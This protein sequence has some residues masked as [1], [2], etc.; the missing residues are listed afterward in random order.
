MVYVCNC[1]SCRRKVYH[2]FTAHMFLLLVCGIFASV[3]YLG[4]VFVW[5]VLMNAHLV[6][7]Y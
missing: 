1:G 3:W 7:R 2:C 4:M 6:K 5:T